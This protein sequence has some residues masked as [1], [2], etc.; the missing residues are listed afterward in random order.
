MTPQNDD[1]SHVTQRADI[2]AIGFAGICFL[3]CLLVPVLVS[4]APTLSLLSNEWIH[5]GVVLATIPVSLF[6]FGRSMSDRGTYATL[7][8][9]MVGLT[10]LTVAGFVEAAHDYEV[11]LTVLGSI[12]LMTSHGWHWKRHRGAQ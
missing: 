5:K 1:P 7:F 9:M 12:A 8:G 4:L 10:L 11:P 2:L 6:V 3:H